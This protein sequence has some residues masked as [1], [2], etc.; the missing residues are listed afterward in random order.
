MNA[1]TRKIKQL[2]DEIQYYEG[3]LQREQTLL[4][5]PETKLNPHKCIKEADLEI[6]RKKIKQLKALYDESKEDSLPKIREKAQEYTNSF[7]QRHIIGTYKAFINSYVFY[8]SFPLFIALALNAIVAPAWL[9]PLAIPILVFAVSLG[10]IGLFQSYVAESRAITTYDA[11]IEESIWI[12]NSARKLVESCDNLLKDQDTYDQRANVELKP[13]QNILRKNSNIPKDAKYFLIKHAQDSQTITPNNELRKTIPVLDKLAKP[14]GER[15]PKSAFELASPD[16]FGKK[17]GWA[18]HRLSEYFYQWTIVNTVVD[19]VAKLIFMA[20]MWCDS[21]WWR[22]IIFKIRFGSHFY[23]ADDKC[24]RCRPYYH[25][26][27]VSRI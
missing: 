19:F 17:I 12:E 22:S 21:P 3:K 14:L 23:T 4:Q 16:T 11:A 2:Y 18:L 20:I 27:S 9:A 13:V 26:S 6:I 5:T 1:A 10:V 25:N 24:L 8:L 15:L 7:I